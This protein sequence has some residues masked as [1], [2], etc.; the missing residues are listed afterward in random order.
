[1]Q[2][3]CVKT[4]ILIM[5]ASYGFTFGAVED[6]VRWTGNGDGTTWNM[7]SNWLRF[8]DQENWAG[9]TAYPE[10]WQRIYIGY[11]LTSGS[12]TN[13]TIGSG[14]S[15]VSETFYI[16]MD[17][18]PAAS[19]ILNIASGGAYTNSGYVF[20]K[21]ESKA[22]FNINGSFQVRMTDFQGAIVNIEDG[23]LMRI[24]SE[25]WYIRNGT[26][27]NVAEGGTFAITA[28]SGYGANG[29]SGGVVDLQGGV[30]RI[31]GDKT[32]LAQTYISSGFVTAYGGSSGYDLEITYDGSY[33]YIA[34]ISAYENYF[35]GE[36]DGVS[37]NDA[38]NWY[39]GIPVYNTD[40]S[41]AAFLG[42]NATEDISVNITDSGA[43]AVSGYVYHGLAEDS[44]S[45]T[46]NLTTGGELYNVYYYL[47]P[48]GT[49]NI[50]GGLFNPFGTRQLDG[51]VNINAGAYQNRSFVWRIGGLV[52][53]ENGTF[54]IFNGTRFSES[55]ND[56]TTPNGY[57]TGTIDIRGGT[58]RMQGDCRVPLNWHIANG[59]IVAY[60][61]S[62][63]A[64]LNVVY[65]ADINRTIVSAREYWKKSYGPS[66]KDGAIDVLLD[67]TLSWMLDEAVTASSLWVGREYRS[68][69]D[70]S[71]IVDINDLGVLA[72]YFLADSGL[73]LEA[74]D[75]NLD[76]D[77]NVLDFAV[78]AEEWDSMM[79]FEETA[80]L[81][82]DINQ[83]FDP[84]QPI[85]YMPDELF[86]PDMNYLWRVDTVI[87]GTVTTG[88][89]WQFK[90]IRSD[91]RDIAWLVENHP[92][93]IDDIFNNLDLTNPELS[94]VSQAVNNG[95]MGKACKLLLDYY[96][97]CDSGSWLR[98]GD[99][100]AATESTIA[101]ADLILQDIY[102]HYSVTGQVPRTAT[103]TLNWKY[104]GPE[105]DWEWAW[106]HNR[107]EY[108]PGILE[109]AYR[110][111]GE[112]VYIERINE[113]IQDWV[114][115]CPYSMS[116]SNPEWRGL[117]VAI[118]VG[119]FMGL[120][121]RLYDDPNFNDVT[122]LLILST[123][124][125]HGQF[126]LDN[127]QS[128]GNWLLT[129]MRGLATVGA[130]WPE[131]EQSASYLNYAF[132]NVTP[133]ISS[134]VL[135]DGAYCELTTGYHSVALK[136]F[137]FIAELARSSGQ[138][139]DEEY[140]N[141]LE[142]MWNYLAMTIRPNGLCALNSDTDL[143]DY[144]S[145][146]IAAADDFNR[147]DWV[148]VATNGLEGTLPA[149]EPSVYFPWAGQLVSR[150]GWDPNDHWSFFDIG[151]YGTSGGHIHYDKLHFS[152][153][154][155]GRNILVDAGRAPYY[156][157]LADT[158]RAYSIGTASHN[159]VTIAGQDQEVGGYTRNSS[160]QADDCVI[161][162]SYDFAKGTV[163]TGY[164]NTTGIAENTRLLHYERGK[165]WVIV[166]RFTTDQARNIEALWHYHP[167]CTVVVDGQEVTSDDV[168]E[169]NIRIV[170]VG[171]VNWTLNM[172]QGQLNPTVQGWYFKEY[173]LHEA[174]PTAVYSANIPVGDTVFA[175][176]VIP[177][178]GTP[179]QL[180]A[181]ILSSTST[182]VTIK[183]TEAP[184][185]ENTV[186][187]SY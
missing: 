111:T 121:Y 160:S 61:G 91:E 10:N 23:G 92:E 97:D 82:H 59:D 57:F 126:L 81:T 180:S 18:D 34:T 108:L 31:N 80:N 168:G 165:Y 136:E 132:S 184:G 53:I 177:G 41:Q 110:T 171:S 181:E 155:Y 63:D 46:L 103:G 66:P 98:G 153:T 162:S 30:F 148:Y 13:V 106:G 28:D 75:I 43:R 62:P 175:W 130:G 64:K 150:S 158:Y 45:S 67:S 20:G 186:V 143:R 117:E 2:K 89:V 94:M 6:T 109:R 164:T 55:A 139:V 100:A 113:E 60:G 12:E 35:T 140:N 7:N 74:A 49:I 11:G 4:V 90:T 21:A 187:M 178:L 179:D 5:V 26:T 170:P 147:P 88:D 65:N 161:T 123:L 133:E 134:Q 112:T 102:T 14:V 3:A 17:S 144:R 120:F 145:R 79:T 99:V 22:V 24:Y 44:V 69:L 107:L 95:N 104:L 38:A 58:L 1:M 40:N 176:I 141:W 78:M 93:F 159:V 174:N 83:G 127:H 47:G 151:P 167:D 96:A 25:W 70:G 73:A 172:V 50:N 51:V 125:N 15:A 137:D 84:E 48:K 157:D 68:D 163:T 71:G 183:I 154:A 42:P 131:L 9:G 77:V 146:I 182:S 33:T 118:R 116:T 54:S 56:F 149:G 128:G 166:D 19:V 105:N 72:S 27:I 85:V 122:K 156:G 39:R 76:F 169:G 129:E 185:V 36:G 8:G 86:R 173:G 124:R 115:N 32:A 138:P 142:L 29:Y 152:A 135:P 16:G 52:I 87:D 37:W 119:N 114:L 101:S